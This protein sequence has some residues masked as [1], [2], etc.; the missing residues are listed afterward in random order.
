MTYQDRV[1][2]VL[3]GYAHLSNRPFGTRGFWGR[4]WRSNREFVGRMQ[5]GVRWKMW[6]PN[7]VHRSFP[8]GFQKTAMTMIMGSRRPESLLYLLQVRAAKRAKRAT[9][10]RLAY[11]T[12][13]LFRPLSSL[14]YIDPDRGT[15]V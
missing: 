15:P 6:Q 10:C 4:P 11:M 3:P 2:K 1:L 13:L 14:A 5:Y 12:L 8:I 9:V 7:E